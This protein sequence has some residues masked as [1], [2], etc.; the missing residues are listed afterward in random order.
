MSNEI[1]IA[2]NV[3]HYDLVSADTTDSKLVALWVGRK[4]SE[5]TRVQYQRAWDMFHAAVGVPLQSVNFEMLQRWSDSLAGSA[6][7]RRVRVNAIKSLFAFA[8]RTGYLRLDPASLL[9]SIKVKNELAARILSEDQALAM[10]HRTTKQRDN[11][12][13]RVLYASGGR[14]SEICGLT[15]ADVTTNGDSGQLTLFGKGQKTRAVKLSKGTYQALVALD[16]GKGADQ[17]VF[18]SQRGGPLDPS[19]VHRIVRD[20]AARAGIVG[21]VS[22]HWLRH[23]HASHALDRGASP[24]LVRDTLGHASLATTSKYSHAKPGDSSALCLAV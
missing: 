1:V 18:V 16:T 19:Q 5:A 2:S 6:N 10:I 9:E 11:V 17:P 14:V 22:P 24:V 20:A 21:D 8:V 13:L 3:G 15:W 7:T 12:L 4:A 23:S